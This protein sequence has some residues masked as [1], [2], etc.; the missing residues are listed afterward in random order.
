MTRT[1]SWNSLRSGWT[2]LRS[3]STSRSAIK[4]TENLQSSSRTSSSESSPLR[5]K[6]MTRFN[7]WWKFPTSI[8]SLMTKILPS[9]P[10]Q[11]QPLY[12]PNN[13]KPKRSRRNSKWK[14]WSWRKL[15]WLR[16]WNSKPIM[17][18]KMVKLRLNT[19]TS[20]CHFAKMRRKIV[21]LKLNKELP[22]N[23]SFWIRD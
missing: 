12:K 3:L 20:E 6:K 19:S 17:L 21:K 11:S 23:K 9:Q 22:R 8:N 1:T 7:L 10:W 14:T 13:S 4:N 18:Q 5:P 16:L 2:A 15:I